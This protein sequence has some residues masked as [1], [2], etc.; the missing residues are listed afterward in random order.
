MKQLVLVAVFL[1]GGLSAARAQDYI[2]ATHSTA[3]TVLKKK[4]PAKKHHSPVTVSVD[5]IRVLWKGPAGARTEY[6]YAFDDNHLCFSETIITH[7]DSCLTGYLQQVLD[8]KNFG[9]KK[10]NE[11]QYISRFADNLMIE[12]SADEALHSFSVLRVDWT[13][14]LYDMLI[15]D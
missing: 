5:T 10:I 3:E 9:W 11:N 8:K 12:L 15:K 1:A 13:R 4:Y 14:E 6:I 2:N 7:C